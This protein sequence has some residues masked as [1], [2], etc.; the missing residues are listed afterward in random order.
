M[1][2]V[3]LK[4]IVSAKLKDDGATYDAGFVVG[5]AMKASVTTETNDVKLY[6][7]DGVGESDKSFKSG[8]ISLGVDDLI[9][10]VYCDLLGHKHT[11]GSES[12]PANPELVV[13]SANDISPFVG[14]GFYGKVVRSGKVSYIAKWLKKVQFAEPADES[15]TKG[16]TIAYQ[17][18]T[19]EGDVFALDN[20]EWKEQAEFKNE[21]DAIAWL[22]E[23]ANITAA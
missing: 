23:K 11:P 10:K 6:A 13:A 3:G 17:S 1:A 21:A 15:E 9:N 5:K 4:Y 18:P 12:E 19:I 7:D 2:R 8:K 22:N 20:G 14:V 16:E